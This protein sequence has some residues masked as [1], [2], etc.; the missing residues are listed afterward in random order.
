MKSDGESSDKEEKDRERESDQSN[1]FTLPF[2]L[3]VWKERLGFCPASPIKRPSNNTRNRDSTR[4][5]PG[6][7][8]RGRTRGAQV[9]RGARFAWERF[10]LFCLVSLSSTALD[11]GLIAS[12]LC[13]S[14]ISLS[15]CS[16]LPCF[17]FPFGRA[18]VHILIRRSQTRRKKR[19]KR[20]GQKERASKATRGDKAKQS[21]H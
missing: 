21:C 18:A 4:P 1:V 19:R 6:E 11:R 17:L 14:C 5:R 13:S 12:P 9:E 8:V 2:S 15:L 10:F 16:L 7:R 3:V 20:E